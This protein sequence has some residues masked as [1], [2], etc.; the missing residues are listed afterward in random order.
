MAIEASLAIFTLWLVREG[1]G[2]FEFSYAWNSAH[3]SF[4][5]AIVA[6]LL[7]IPVAHAAIKLE[8]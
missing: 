7:A 3:A 6:V 8:S 1:A 5:A 4:I 2:G